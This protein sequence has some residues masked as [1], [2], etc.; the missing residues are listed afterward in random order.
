MDAPESR[1]EEKLSI[2][3]DEKDRSDNGPWTEDNATRADSTQLTSLAEISAQEPTSVYPREEHSGAVA[4]AGPSTSQPNAAADVPEHQQQDVEEPPQFFPPPL[5]EEQ[6][7]VPDVRASLPAHEFQIHDKLSH[8]Y[9]FYRRT[10]A[11][12]QL[13]A[14]RRSTIF[15]EQACSM[16]IH[17][18]QIIQLQHN[19]DPERKHMELSKRTWPDLPWYVLK[20]T[21]HWILLPCYAS[22][23]RKCGTS[24]VAG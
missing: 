16:C 6:E 23:W 15:Q 21:M 13:E 24:E 9:V 3:P 7:L 1:P 12:L 22:T 19:D 17:P 2:L 14:I 20:Q 10:R 4:E 11:I 18:D 5:A 8:K